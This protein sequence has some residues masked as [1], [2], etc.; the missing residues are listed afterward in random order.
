MAEVQTPYSSSGTQRHWLFDEVP[1]KLPYLKSCSFLVL[2]D[3]FIAST[4]RSFLAGGFRQQLARN[5]ELHPGQRTP[6]TVEELRE[7]ALLA[8]EFR[9]IFPLDT[10]FQDE[11]LPSSQ[12]T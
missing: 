12:R 2:L 4:A 7:L 8:S 5:G 11:T 1:R 3:A 10:G 6:N 9:A